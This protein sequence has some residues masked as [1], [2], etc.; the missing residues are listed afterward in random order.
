[1]PGMHKRLCLIAGM[2]L[3]VVCVW[4]ACSP[5]RSY[6]A[7]DY[8]G[9]GEVFSEEQLEEEKPE[10][11]VESNS[12]SSQISSDAEEINNAVGNTVDDIRSYTDR[13]LDSATQMFDT[14]RF[15]KAQSEYV[16]PDIVVKTEEE[17]ASMTYAMGDIIVRLVLAASGILMIH[18]ILGVS[19]DSYYVFWSQK[20]YS[21][22]LKS[23]D[24]TMQKYGGPSVSKDGS[25]S[26][27]TT[28][29][30]NNSTNNNNN[31]GAQVVTKAVN[32]VVGPGP[33]ILYMLLN[34]IVF[35]SILIILIT[36]VSYG[37]HLTA[38]HN[39]IKLFISVVKWILSAFEGAIKV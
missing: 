36:L 31:Q 32:A 12:S 14:S 34:S 38:I 24:L 22:F 25:V 8:S 20:K 9:E 16:T 21:F 37:F 6:A 27:G 30:I 35:I 10:S 15:D 1:M 39:F 19:F 13:M 28:I 33:R 11:K 17:S 3:I 26:Q 5:W 23:V 4:S 7:E 29:N 18:S 2:V